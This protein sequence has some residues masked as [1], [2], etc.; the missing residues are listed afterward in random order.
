MHW[1]V[2]CWLVVNQMSFVDDPIKTHSW[3]ECVITCLRKTAYF[4]EW[5]SPI[6]CDENFWF[7]IDQLLNSLR[8]FITN[9]Y[10][11]ITFVEKRGAFCYVL[12]VRCSVIRFAD[13]IFHESFPFQAKITWRR[14]KRQ[15]CGGYQKE[16]RRRGEVVENVNN[17]THYNA[18]GGV[19]DSSRLKKD[20]MI[21]KALL[22][23]SQSWW[24]RIWTWSW[25]VSLS[26]SLSQ[27]F[28]RS[29]CEW[30]RKWSRGFVMLRSS[31]RERR[32]FGYSAQRNGANEWKFYYHLSM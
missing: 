19:R 14:G 24:W 4:I 26:Q 16:V 10:H 5:W 1:C 27:S 29:V 20:H 18:F 25:W 28:S 15:A 2:V 22:L 7:V 17:T 30:E 12:W 23:M 11:R 32:M 13:D 31:R 6:F 21:C 8:F 9:L 3:K